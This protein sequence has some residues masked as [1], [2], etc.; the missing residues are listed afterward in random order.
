M[1]QGLWPNFG[2]EDLNENTE[3]LIATAA[4]HSNRDTHLF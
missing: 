3:L 1:C 2:N 4:P